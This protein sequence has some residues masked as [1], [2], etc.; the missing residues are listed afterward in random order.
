M[1]RVV[2]PRYPPGPMRDERG[3]FQELRPVGEVRRDDTG[4]AAAAP[5]PV[6]LE[7]RRAGAI[8]DAALDL[9]RENFGLFVLVASLIWS[10]QRVTAE[11]LGVGE[12]PDW[13]S[14]DAMSNAMLL[15]MLNQ[16]IELMILQLASVAIALIAWPRLRGESPRLGAVL[17]RMVVCAVPLMVLQFGFSLLIVAGGCCLCLPGI[18]VAV[19]FSLIGIT[20]CVERAGFFGCM[21][22]SFELTG[23]EGWGTDGLASFLRGVGVVGT[24]FI[25][26]SAFTLLSGALDQP[27]Y[28]P[29]LQDA[30]GLPGDVFSVLAVVVT[31]LFN[32]LASVFMSL[33]LLTYYLDCRVRRD[34]LD[35]RVILAQRV[36]HAAA[37][38]GAGAGRTGAP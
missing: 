11:L 29:M 6:T 27:G 33:A 4:A 28:R 16:A 1:A 2:P 26:Y 23:G 34:G 32:G 14:P 3:T 22:R 15:S 37:G 5:S 13:A 10:V 7:P 35:L 36:A 20:F 18:F 38:A 19:R 31:S 25:V 21:R 17:L 9:A 24:G 8:L 30:L 12:M